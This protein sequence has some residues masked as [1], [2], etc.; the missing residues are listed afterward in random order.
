LLD[1]LAAGRREPI[2][3]VHNNDDSEGPGAH[4]R[5]NLADLIGVDAQ[6]VEGGGLAELDVA[7]GA[8][9]RRVRR[10]RVAAQERE[11]VVVV[12]GAEQRRG[13]DGLERVEH[14][15]VHGVAGAAA[16]GRGV[17]VCARGARDEVGRRRRWGLKVGCLLVVGFDQVALLGA[18]RALSTATF[19]CR[20]SST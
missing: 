9:I 18:R 3:R 14:V 5:D 13:D 12:R 11:Q 1:R 10:R 6:P 8:Q 17:V 4:A 15:L 7:L 19:R 2:H 16:L 20:E